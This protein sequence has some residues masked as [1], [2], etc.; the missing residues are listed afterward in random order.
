[1]NYPGKPPKPIKDELNMGW[2]I[3][4]ALIVLTC[5]LLLYMTAEIILNP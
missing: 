5:G 1:M 2:T 3:V 4:C